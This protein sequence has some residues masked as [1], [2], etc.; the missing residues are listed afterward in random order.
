M[1]DRGND[2]RQAAAAEL[3]AEFL[4][5]IIDAIA[6]PVFVKDRDFR[7][8]LVNR[9]LEQMLGHT[10]PDLLGKDD[11]DFFPPEQAE[12]FRQK[13]RQMFA[14]DEAV[15]IDEEPITDAFGRTHV[16]CTT[17]VPL[18]DAGG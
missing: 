7:F 10:R 6:H 13:D 5:G 8:V 2:S 17:K 3:D 9:A 15:W 1:P 16:L 12:F 4:S 14:T 18:R 11:F